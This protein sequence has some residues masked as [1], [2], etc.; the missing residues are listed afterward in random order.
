ML[1]VLTCQGWD[2][3]REGVAPGPPAAACP[4]S[5]A[6][7]QEQFRDCLHR[8]PLT[9]QPRHFVYRLSLSWAAP[10]RAQQLQMISSRVVTTAAESQQGRPTVL[11]LPYGP[12]MSI[13]DLKPALSCSSCGRAS[14]KC[15]ASGSSRR[16]VATCRLKTV[17]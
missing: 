3:V 7:S 9:E 1:G 2:I 11:P 8:Y 17:D 6:H 15:S 10:Q 13:N 4:E 16:N 12:H 14:A 5:P